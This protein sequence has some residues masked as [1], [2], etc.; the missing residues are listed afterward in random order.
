LVGGARTAYQVGAL[1][2]IGALLAQ[3]QAT[4]FPFQILV[5]TSAGAIN[6]SFLA[7]QAQQ[8][9][10]ALQELSSFWSQIRS[11]DVFR[12]NIW[13][14]V[15]FSKV[16]A[17]FFLSRQARFKGAI[18]DSS[19]LMDTL[20]RC[21]SVPGIQAALQHRVLDALAVTASSYTTGVHWT[22]CQTAPGRAFQSLSRPGRRVEFDTITVQHLMA[23]SAIPFLFPAKAIP[24]Q[25][26][27]EFFGDGSMRQVSPLS[28]AL[29][30]G[31]QK[32]LVIGVGQ[33]E[34]SGLAPGQDK[35]R[36]PTL[37]SI[38]GHAMAS[39]FHD[40]LLADVEQTQRVSQTLKKLPSATAQGL[41]YRSV[42]VMAIQ[43]TR[44]LDELAHRHVGE[45]PT[46]TR[47]A[48]S[49]LGVLK[50][51]GGAL[52]SYL[53]FEPGFIQALMAMGESDALQRK[54]ELLAFFREAD[55]TA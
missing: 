2:A 1:K 36:P 8:G 45:L 4:R 32:V 29:N 40:T 52:A 21:I 47:N 50:G 44:S 20:S 54:D 5:G 39:V 28:P 46:A 6:A 53:L 31:A 48:L 23:S 41:P 7:G 37:A 25:G 12:L 51:G 17:A 33:P 9:L 22:F 38:A 16:A 24:I 11:Q 18:L 15:R 34:R 27:A 49:G 19:P 10:A 42:D 13:P 35:E 26:Q 3:T 30:L 55:K 14:G 43:P